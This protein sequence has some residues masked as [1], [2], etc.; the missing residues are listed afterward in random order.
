MNKPIFWRVD[1]LGEKG[2]EKCQ[3]RG[4][5]VSGE[6]GGTVVAKF[7]TMNGIEGLIS[8]AEG[9]YQLSPITLPFL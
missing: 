2:I 8:L 9:Q 6:I 4:E 5:I 7:K 1:T 3:M